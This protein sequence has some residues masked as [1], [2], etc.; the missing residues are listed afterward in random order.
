MEV[1]PEKQE[2]TVSA[3]S[4]NAQQL[5]ATIGALAADSRVRVEHHATTMAGILAGLSS[6]LEI[7]LQG[8]VGDYAFLASQQAV[9]DLFGSAGIACGHSLQSGSLLVRGDVGDFLAAHAQGGYLAVHGK[10]GHFVGYGLSGC[11]VLVRSRC[12]DGAGCKMRSGT[13]V[14]GNGCGQELGS[15]MTGGTIYVRGE[16]GSVAEGVIPGRL[17]EKDSIRLSL[18]LVRA[19]IKTTYEKFQVYR[20]RG[21]KG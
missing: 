8:S 1:E 11:D 20:A 9:I 18:M 3:Q 13:L 6:S 12:G 16:V 2:I 19:G 10:A 17:K 5:L 15:G 4:L 21:D 7:S 14:L